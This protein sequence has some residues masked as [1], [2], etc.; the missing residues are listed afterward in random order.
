MPALLGSG[1]VAF[2]DA[3]DRQPANT[4]PARPTTLSAPS[5]CSTGQ[6]LRGRDPGL[7]LGNLLGILGDGAA[8]PV[9]QRGRHRLRHQRQFRRVRPGGRRGLQRGRQL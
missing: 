4:P 9:N 7:G 6:H 3:A 1:S 2:A 5:T 8:G